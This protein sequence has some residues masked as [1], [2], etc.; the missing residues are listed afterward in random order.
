MSTPGR[1]R[2]RRYACLPADPLREGDF[3]LC[4]VQDEHLEAIRQW[5]NAQIDV[6]RQAEPLTVEQQVR[7]YQDHI[8]P[9]LDEPH[10]R[11]LLLT[12]LEG[13]RPVGYGGLVHIAWEHRRAEV[14]FLMDPEFTRDPA[15]YERYFA[16]F[17]RL[18]QR[19]AF[20][21]LGFYR[22]FTECYAIRGEQIRLLEKHGFQLEG[23]MR[24]HVHIGG[25]PVDSLIHGLLRP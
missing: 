10:P 21:E 25:A 13:E 5:R 18:L 9:T 19:L 4:T 2:T 15:V 11:N 1:A 7:Y 22:L 16:V 24:G 12:F 14:S 8:W 3:S 20:G 17:L 23:R 6:L